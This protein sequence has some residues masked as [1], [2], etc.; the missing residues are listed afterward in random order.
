LKHSASRRLINFRI[1]TNSWI[2]MNG[3][4]ERIC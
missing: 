1:P 4:N 3:N 2:C